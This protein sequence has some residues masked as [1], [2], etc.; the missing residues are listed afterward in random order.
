MHTGRIPKYRGWKPSGSNDFTST[1]LRR[2]E[3]ILNK[4]KQAEPK[5]EEKKL[6][7][8]RVVPVVVEEKRP[9]WRPPGSSSAK[10]YN[11]RRVEIIPVDENSKTNKNV[12]N[13]KTKATSSTTGVA[14]PTI[15]KSTSISGGQEKPSDL[16]L[17]RDPNDTS[18]LFMMV[19]N[20]YNNRNNNASHQV[21]ENN[22]RPTTSNTRAHSASSSNHVNRPQTTMSTNPRLSSSSSL[23]STSSQAYPLPPK[24][25][26]SS[27]GTNSNRIVIE[28]TIEHHPETSTSFYT[29][30][31]TAYRLVPADEP[32]VY[33]PE[34]NRT[35]YYYK[36]V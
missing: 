19:D 24:T 6:E 14:M 34:S 23:M 22:S 8:I 3:M 26:S 32:V 21:N 15:S 25:P 17:F 16:I 5:P 35:L 30:P 7:A 29:R 11:I 20:N 13:T 12:T 27:H 4:E 2:A 10:V 1:Y 36:P 9:S 28:T 33:L 31:V 18:Q